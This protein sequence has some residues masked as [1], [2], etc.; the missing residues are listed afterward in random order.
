MSMAKAKRDKIFSMYCMNIPNS[1]IAKHCNVHPDTIYKMEKRCDWKNLREEVRTKAKETSELSK[2]DKQNQL[3]DLILGLF[4]NNVKANQSEAQ[5]KI[6]AR[7]V[8]EA[9]KLQRLIDNLSTENV[10]IS[11]NETTQKVNEIYEKYKTKLKR[12]DEPASVDE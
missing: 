10:A 8:L 2:L 11:S 5:R 12:L 7:D 3:I 9:I 6:S 1:I 4:A